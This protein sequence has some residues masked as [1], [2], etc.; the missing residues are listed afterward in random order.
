MHPCD[1]CSIRVCAAV[2]ISSM[3]HIACRPMSLKC[4]NE[5][6][7]RATSTRIDTQV[8]D[9]YSLHAAPVTA[10]IVVEKPQPTA[11]TATCTVLL[12]LQAS[13]SHSQGW[14]I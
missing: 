9:Y 7:T 4:C 3:L 5:C 6:G 2:G 1:G 13:A 11:C 10:L 14:A 8:P 12:A